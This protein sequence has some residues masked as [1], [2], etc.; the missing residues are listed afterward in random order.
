MEITT[1]LKILSDEIRLRI[2]NLLKEYPLCVGELQTILG[3]KQS[4]L[5]RH[6]DK[7][8]MS[9]LIVSKKRAQWVYYQINLADFEE[10]SFIKSLISKDITIDPIFREDLI[11]L[12][13]YKASGLCCQ[14]LRDIDFTYE[15]IKFIK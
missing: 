4:N 12:K 6:L 13:R 1:L 11:K 7:L 9:N 14:D 10:Y 2:L 3:V 8:K 15:K 5:S